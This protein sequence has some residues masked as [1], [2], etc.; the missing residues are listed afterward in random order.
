[1]VKVNTKFIANPSFMIQ[2]VGKQTITVGWRP[3]YNVTSVVSQE[4]EA[5]VHNI[6]TNEINGVIYAAEPEVDPNL[7]GGGV[8][9]G[10]AATGS[11]IG[12][13]DMPL[14]L[15]PQLIAGLLTSNPSLSAA[16]D[17]MGFS[18]LSVSLQPS[19]TLKGS[20]RKTSPSATGHLEL[21]MSGIINFLAFLEK[22]PIH[23]SKLNVRASD[24]KYLP[25]VLEVLTPNIFS[26][27]YD[28]QVVNI[29][30]DSNMYQNQS[31]I[32]TLDVDFF[33]TR[34]SILRVDSAFN[35]TETTP[36]LSMDFTFDKY[37]SLEKA[38]VENYE[39][40]QT[41]AGIEGAIVEE[42][43][44]INATTQQVATVV[45][46]LP[47]TTTA[48]TIVPLTPWRK[49]IGGGSSQPATAKG[50]NF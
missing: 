45:D 21:E 34:T 6:E 38:F 10:E 49:V 30:A 22:N 24:V 25:A 27:Q 12:F 47:T 42:V 23:V 44:R 36:A 7:R 3:L 4:I 40:L 14:G 5:E 1:M 33:I 32:V 50:N 43:E 16:A 39:L 17:G 46:K 35:E 48:A 37:L 2:S 28:R 26:G 19:M 41:N 18:P 9:A 15:L 11:Y 20:N 8:R 31:N 13:A 29:L